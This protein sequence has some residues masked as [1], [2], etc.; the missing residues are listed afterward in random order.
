M[1]AR[2]TDIAVQRQAMLMHEGKAER[3]EGT[4]LA[5]NAIEGLAG[6]R[7]V[8]RQALTAIG[9]QGALQFLPRVA[10]L[11]GLRQVDHGEIAIHTPILAFA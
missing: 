11:V 4:A 8:L 1:T 3:R 9:A 6:Q 2:L 7:L 10:M 5:M